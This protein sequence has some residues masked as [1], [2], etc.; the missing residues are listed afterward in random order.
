M[1]KIY[2]FKSAPV[3]THF[4]TWQKALPVYGKELFN[5][6]QTLESEISANFHFSTNWYKGVSLNDCL[7][8]KK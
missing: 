8:E 6:W 1:Q 3:F 4:G 5:T 7:K 2:G